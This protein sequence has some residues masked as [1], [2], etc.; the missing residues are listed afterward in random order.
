MTDGNAL[1]TIVLNFVLYPLLGRLNIGQ[2]VSYRTL[3]CIQ[4]PTVFIN[5]QSLTAYLLKYCDPLNA[6]DFPEHYVPS[7]KFS[8]W[9]S[10]HVC[11]LL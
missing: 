9:G 11:L 6:Q 1:P 10:G 7:A 4:K 3:Q 2:C 5:V 8:C